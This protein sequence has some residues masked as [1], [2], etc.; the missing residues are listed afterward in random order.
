MLTVYSAISYDTLQRFIM[1]FC[2][3]YLAQLNII[4][5]IIIIIIVIIIVIIAIIK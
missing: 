4:V 2:P 1:E 5:I 3:Y